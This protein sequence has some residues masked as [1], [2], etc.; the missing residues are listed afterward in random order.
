MNDNVKNGLMALAAV[1]LIV[2]GV[3]WMTP[4]GNEVIREV[5]NN[6]GAVSGPDRFSPDGCESVNGLKTCSTQVA[7]R[8]ATTT[9]CSIQTPSATSTLVRTSLVVKTATTTAITMRLATSTTAFA[10]T[11][12]K[13]SFALGSGEKG[14]MSWSPTTTENA[15]FGPNLYVVWAP[16]GFIGADTSLFLGSCQAEFK[17]L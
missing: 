6:V 2:V 3:M 16:T 1:V 17:V 9:P 11:T 14:A 12:L 13:Y 7:L 8:T 15:I 4:K 5:T 10:T